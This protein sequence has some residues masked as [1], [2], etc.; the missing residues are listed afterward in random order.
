[1]DLPRRELEG[2]FLRNPLLYRLGIEGRAFSTWLF[3][4][5][6][7]YALAHAGLIFFVAFWVLA[8]KYAHQ[9]DGKDIGFWSAGMLVYGVCIFTANVVLMFKH[10]THYVISFFLF[11]LCM[12]NYFL[13]F[14]LFS[15]TFKNEIGNL[16][17]PTFRMRVVWLIGFFVIVTVYLVELLYADC[18]RMWSSKSTEDDEM[19]ALLENQQ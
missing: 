2:Y 5:W 7:I 15:A 16:F 19:D 14:W 8:Q 10:Y 6:L 18:K 12:G 1:M 9:S 4:K 13:F 11:F 17:G 3:V